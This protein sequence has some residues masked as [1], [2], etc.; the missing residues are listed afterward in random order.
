MTQLEYLQ[1]LHYHPACQDV[2]SVEG[3]VRKD[4]REYWIPREEKIK[5]KEGCTLTAFILYGYH[6]ENQ[7]LEAL[8]EK[9]GTTKQSLYNLAGN[10]RVPLR[11]KSEA[12]ERRILRKILLET[13]LDFSKN[14]LIE[15]LV[16]EYCKLGMSGQ[17]LAIKYHVHCRTIYDWLRK[18]GVTIR[19]G[20]T[21]LLKGKTFEQFYGEAKSK[22]IKDKMSEVRKG[23]SLEELYDEK[24]ARDIKDKMSQAKREYW[25]KKRR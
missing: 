18:A 15:T 17:E 21:Q 24:R 6:F 8:A 14:E 3:L 20:I 23:K 10:L 1:D 5:E 19:P 11:S 13:K 25:E 22:E 12:Q 9:I 7:S 4:S 16:F 2:K